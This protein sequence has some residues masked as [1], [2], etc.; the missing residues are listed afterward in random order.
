MAINTRAR[1]GQFSL[2]RSLQHSLRSHQGHPGDSP[3]ALPGLPG[4]LLRDGDRCVCTSVR[5][6]GPGPLALLVHR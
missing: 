1:D 3:D 6:S 5:A 4:P 2:L